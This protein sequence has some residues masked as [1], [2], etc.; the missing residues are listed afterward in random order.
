M[1]LFLSDEEFRLCSHDSSLVAEKADSYIQN[2]TLQ[3]ENFKAQVEASSITAEQTCA[4]LEQKY[5]SLSAEFSNLEA[6]NSRIS[7]SLEKTLSDLAEAQAH[8]HQLNI[9]A[10]GKDGDAERLSVEI[11]ELHKSKRQLLDLLDQRDSEIAEKNTTIKG[12]LDKIVNLT[13][14]SALKEARLHDSEA[15]LAR[16]RATHSRLSQ[17]KELIERHNVWLNDELTAKLN[18]LIELRKAHTE[19]EADMTAKLVGVE[20]RVNDCSSALKWN[21]ERVRELELKL[22]SAQEELCSSKNTAAANEE[23]FSAE[24]STVNKLV[25]LYKE[26]SEEWSRKAGELE[27]VI[28]A[29]E[30]H[31]GQVENDYKEKLEKEVSARNDIE[32]EA[33]ALKDKLEKCESEIEAA[34]KANECSLLSICTFRSD[35]SAEQIW[36]G[37]NETDDKKERSLMLVPKIPVGVSG[38]ALAASLLRDGWSLAKMYEK[39]QEAADALRHE[40]LG[41]KHAEAV[42][43]RVLYE[44]EEKAEVVLDERAEHER[45]V[46]AYNLMN[47]KLQ[48][49][50]SEYAS[51]ENTI[52]ELKADLRR[53]G[54]DYDVA[55]KEIVDLQKQVTVLLKECRDIQL[56]CGATFEVYAIDSPTIPMIEMGDESEAEKVISERLLTFKNING[57][58][59]Q[60][61]QLRSLVRSL[62]KQ[63]EERDEELR[64]RFEMELQ[65][66]TDGATSK[67]EA[68][69]ERSEEQGRMIESLHSAVA[70]YKR[71]YEEE[72]KNHASYPNSAEAIPDGRKDLML[73]FEGSQ[74]AS[75]KSHEKAAERARNLEEDLSKARGEAISLRL[76]RDKVAMEAN[77]ARERLD[78]F[79]KEFDHQRDEINGVLARNVEFSQ[80]IVD[81]QRKLRDSSDSLQASE[82]LSRKLSMDVSILKHER[83][84]LI[85]SEKRA[86]DEV[87]SLSE[88]VHRLRASLDTIQSAGDVREDA[89]AMEIRKQ[90]EY[91]KRVEREWAEAKKELQEERDHVRTLTHDREQTIQN[92]MRQVEVVGKE[93][94]DALRAVSAAE[95]RA[96]TAEAHSSMLE[97]KLKGSERKTVENNGGDG[98]SISS[99]N[100]VFVDPQNA[101]EE[102][103]KLK[104]EAQAYKDHM[105]QYK[106]ISQVN[107]AALKQMESAHEKFKAEAEKFKKSLEAEV[108]SLQERI[109]ELEQD[110]ILKSGESASAAAGKEEALSV[111]SSEIDRLKEENARKTSQLM[112]MEIQISSLKE[113]MEKEHLRWRTAQNNY[114]RQVILQSETIQE[115]T[116]ASQALATLQEEAS[117]LRKLADTQ[118]SENDILKSTW[119]TEKSMLQESKNEAERKYNE[120][121]EQNKILH[122]RLEALH[123]KLAEKDRISAGLS[124]VS[125]SPGPQG[126]DDIQNVINYLRRSKE[127]AETE[128]SLLKQEKLRLQSQLESALK[129]SEIAQT[130]LRAERENSRAI[131]FSD[132][133]FKSL[134]IQVREINLLR[135]SNMQIREENKHNF[136]E[137]QKL[138][139]IAQKAKLDTEHLESLLR[140]KQIEIDA[141]KKEIEMQKIEREHLECRISELLERSKNID[142]EDYDRMKEDSQQSQIKLREKEIEV[143]ETKKL[144]SEKQ[145]RISKLEQDLENIQLERTQMEKMVNEI[146]ATLKS[147]VEK[148]KRQQSLFKKRN[149][150]LTKEKEEL[151]TKSDALIKEK[152]ELIKEKQA[153]CKQIEDSKNK[154]PIGDIASE[155]TALKEKLKEKDTRIQMLEKTLEKEKSRRLKTEKTVLDLAKTVQQEKQKLLEELE[156]HKNANSQFETSGIQANQLSS[157]TGVD[158]Q[159]AAYLRAVDKFDC[160]VDEARSIPR[161]TSPVADT[162]SRGQ[163]GPSQAIITQPPLIGTT[164]SPQLK[165]TEEREKGPSV[166]KPS[167]EA[168]KT[169][170][171][172]I[173]PR[174]ERS[175]EP[176]G[177]IEIFDME[178]SSTAEGVKF[179]ISQDP[180]P[181]G[182]LILPQPSSARKRL[183]SSSVSEMREESLIQQEAYPDVAPLSKKP[184]GPDSPKDAANEQ[185]ILPVAESPERTPVMDDVVDIAADF[186]HA[187]NE[188][189]VDA[190]NDEELDTG[191]GPIKEPKEPLDGINQCE[192]Q[193]EHNT[194]LVELAEKPEE[195]FDGSLKGAEV[196]NS[197]QSTEDAENEREEGELDPDGAE[198]QEGVDTLDVMA[199]LEP[200]ESQGEPVT[201]VAASI[202]EGSVVDMVYTSNVAS[203]DALNEDKNEGGEIMEEIPES[204]DM[205]SVNSNNK[206]QSAAELQQS[207]QT[208]SGAGEGSQTII[209]DSGVSKQ[210]SPRVMAE[211]EE[212]TGRTIHLS[213]RARE[214]AALRQAGVQSPPLGRGRGRAISN[215][216]TG[217]GGRGARGRGGRG[218]SSGDND[219]GSM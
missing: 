105:Q 124:S 109:Y 114:E 194:T 173:R 126:G 195:V 83:D 62:S 36:I 179:G 72:L 45:M 17:E 19:F 201:G 112:E 132:E 21:K 152:E 68:V 189:I 140:E 136:E 170:R 123:I 65:K 13:D 191:T 18:S 187:S 102:I 82:E 58:V 166:S 37:E 154:Q 41:R 116:K 206:N 141:C 91:L 16:S 51:F 54:R 104:E 75:K 43:E 9:K 48:Q 85:N 129:A 10:I 125:M 148:Q 66:H 57:L 142:V 156:R 174:L 12:Y 202:E 204:S 149:D 213:S 184:K 128:F 1:P 133:E 94:A 209:A 130:S 7:A 118:K 158:D 134:K 110:I 219:K 172:L 64:E 81:Y 135:E 127:I 49:S 106:E 28:K 151:K 185:S 76:E 196:N 146:E 117:E 79:M 15:E 147:D 207:S 69:L 218:Q 27:G 161:E 157:E 144:F 20:K 215:L 26:S 95:T 199:D 88:R 2:L 60:N 46:E 203:L 160:A 120:I 169:A 35:S 153:L 40:Q 107:E 80:L 56:R 167:T 101:K 99:T 6:E 137:C 34:R 192:L 8:K 38:T 164:A 155:L 139:E 97:A 181:Q 108:L 145:D 50:L 111:A 44:I 63:N 180:E 93:L 143:E 23:H 168:R 4:L 115:L 74:E 11:S 70:M 32:K 200:G 98:H 165:I 31:L 208:G 52:R 186:V 53:R 100:E 30:T 211:S 214:R 67:V 14:N 138:R 42:L 216:K 163:Q 175:Q 150:T 22:T 217:R 78:S 183:A 177:D 193:N 25:E 103:E 71:L 182:E 39:Y 197:Q 3:L 121:N 205:S 190:T 92:A 131:L 29:L 188:E 212:V 178:G 24:L 210:A 90:D 73:L 176:T 198:L 171:R 162:S 122:T 87:R 84:M 47:Q 55:Q 159:T 77:F 89:R 61:V 86:S 33:A 113:D 5:L 96:A 59:E 119:E